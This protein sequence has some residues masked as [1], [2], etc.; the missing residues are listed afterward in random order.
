MGNMLALRD[1]QL[2]A[3]DAIDGWMFADGIQRQAVVLPT[4]AGKTV[5]FS[6]LAKMWVDQRA[7]RFGLPAKVLILVHRDELVDQAVDKLH[8]VAPELHV[9]VV[10]AERD[11]HDAQIIVGSVQTLT[12]ASRTARLGSVGLIIVDECHHATAAGYRRVLERLDGL[13]V[14]SSAVVP[15][16]PKV[17]GFTATLSRTDGGNLG[18]IWQDVAYRLDILDLIEMGHLVDVSGRRVTVDGLSLENVAQQAGDYAPRSLSD[19]LMSADAMKVT[20]DAYLEYAK[21][22]S[23]IVFVPSV[24][25]AMEFTEEFR[26]RG[27]EAATV[28]GAMNKD[29]RR[30]IL[31]LF[32]KGDIQ[33][34]VNCMVLTEGFDAPIASCAVIA[35]PTKSTPLYVQMVGRVLRPFPGKKDA[36]VLDIAGATEEHQLATLADLTSRRLEVV[37]AGMGLTEAAMRERAAGNPFLSDYVVDS[38][39]VDLFNRSRVRWL[40]TKEG[41]WFVRTRD[42]L[43]FVWPDGPDRYK[44]GKR[45]IHSA[46]GEWLETGLDF[47]MAMSWVE[48]D[49]VGEDQANVDGGGVRL[50]TRDASWRRG[51]QAPSEAQI[52]LALRYGIKPTERMTKAE[53]SDLIDIQIAT[54]LLDRALQGGK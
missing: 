18:E 37:P 43:F 6:H 28:Y 33:V 24:E 45:R 42:N 8:Q 50:A 35:R 32:R 49:A 2:R 36:L 21:D 25:S 10:K 38:Y 52:N 11:D 51:R 13:D 16:G 15:G 20:A 48:Q 54:D 46:G 40:R 3:L 31:N 14:V 39:Q 34:L 17:V 22:R 5:I 19:A 23:G 27:I 26:E 47:D 12:R 44:V 41:V 30:S 53:I 29:S 9:G 1:Y 4:G 7:E